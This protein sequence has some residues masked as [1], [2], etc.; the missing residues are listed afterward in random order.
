[1]VRV[2]FA[3]SPTGYLHVGNTRTALMNYLFARKEGGVFILRIEDTDLERSDTLYDASIMEDLKW[4]NIVWDE[5]P[6]RQ[7][8]RTGIYRGYAEA[9]LEKGIAYKCFCSRER[10]E[11]MRRF[12]QEKGIPRDMMEHAETLRRRL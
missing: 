2:R 1:M 3:P 8:E 9:L 6:Y 12:S 7:S 10:L 11:D 4:L 5:G